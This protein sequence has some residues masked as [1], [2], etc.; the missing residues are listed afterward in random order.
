MLT[1]RGWKINGKSYV[2]ET[3]LLI[4][5]IQVPEGYGNVSIDQLIGISDKFA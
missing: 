3:L 1:E 4:R 2:S 5:S